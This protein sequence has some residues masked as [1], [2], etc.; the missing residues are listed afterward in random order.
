[1]ESSSVTNLL[2]LLEGWRNIETHVHLSFT[3]NWEGLE[4]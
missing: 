2:N 3:N 4:I 1:M